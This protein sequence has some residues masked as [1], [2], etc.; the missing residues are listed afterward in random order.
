MMFNNVSDFKQ[1]I[2]HKKYMYIVHLMTFL[3][4]TLNSRKLCNLF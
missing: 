4:Y 2:K 1:N 3:I